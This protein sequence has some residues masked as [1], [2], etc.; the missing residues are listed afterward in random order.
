MS[1]VKRS[2]T[3]VGAASILALLVSLSSAGLALAVQ[4]VTSDPPAN[5]VIDWPG[6]TS[7][8]AAFW[9]KYLADNYQMDVECRKVSESGSFTTTEAYAAIIVKGGQK[10]FIWF[11]AAIG[12]YTTTP[13]VSHY[14]LCGGTVADVVIDPAGSIGGP[15]ADPAYYG[16]F[17][18]TGSDVTI[19][20]RF[21]WYTNYGLHTITKN[22]PAGAIYKTWE[23]WVKPF[24]V[25]RV[26]YQDPDTGAWMNLA[27]LTSVKGVYPA[28]EYQRGFQTQS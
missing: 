23:H 16:I 7:N 3:S 11:D 12:T 10:N 9:E 18:N 15:C 20:F 27:K 26:G 6:S 14:Y 24:T 4:T 1:R 5:V 28:C 21:R 19:R 13:G 22:V 8:N 25:V 17:D 2:F